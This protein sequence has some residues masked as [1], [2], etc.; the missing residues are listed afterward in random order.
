MSSSEFQAYGDFDMSLECHGQLTEEDISSQILQKKDSG[1]TSRHDSDDDQDNNTM[2]SLTPHRGGARAMQAMY[3]LRQFLEKSGAGLE[4]FYVLESEL[5][6]LIA[7][8]STQTSLR[9]VFS[10]PSP[11]YCEY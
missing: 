7:A 3:T 2:A 5:L 11:E 4:Q 6:Q 9:D 10:L 8:A 1:K